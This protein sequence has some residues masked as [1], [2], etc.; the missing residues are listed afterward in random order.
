MEQHEQVPRGR[1]RRPRPELKRVR[2]LVRFNLPSWKTRL[3]SA[4][5]GGCTS[6]VGS[7]ATAHCDKVGSVAPGTPR[8]GRID[9]LRISCMIRAQYM[10]PLEALPLLRTHPA[11]LARPLAHAGHLLRRV[12]QQFTP[13]VHGPLEPQLPCAQPAGHLLVMPLSLAGRRGWRHR[14]QPQVSST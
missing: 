2:R 3:A 5:P 11:S 9:I 13:D 10:L 14:W 7:T 1:W 4:R 6:S 8:G 12:R